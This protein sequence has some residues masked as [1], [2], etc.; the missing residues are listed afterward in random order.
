M[1]ARRFTRRNLLLG[2]AAL[3]ALGLGVAGYA[4]TA[5]AFD[6]FKAMLR[7][8]LPGVRISDASLRAF[9]EDAVIGRQ[10]DFA[11]KLRVL[12]GM[13]RTLGFDA[14]ASIMQDSYAFEKFNRDFLT[15]F[16]VG[17]NFFQLTDP[18]AEEVIYFGRPGACPNSFARF[19]PEGA[20]E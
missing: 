13:V 5:S 9:T 4:A 18:R 19:E 11:P 1:S 6:F 20:L 15:Q 8:Q 2:G 17:S 10:S 3:G 7:S 14:V 12:S 16:L